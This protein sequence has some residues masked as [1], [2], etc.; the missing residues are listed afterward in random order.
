VINTFVAGAGLTVSVCVAKVRP[1][2]VTVTV[3]APARVSLKKKLPTPPLMATEVTVPLK[4][5]V[6]EVSKRRVAE[7][8]NK[9]AVPV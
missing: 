5:P 2:T 4:G 8:D 1:V 9:L 6:E 7:L 3:G